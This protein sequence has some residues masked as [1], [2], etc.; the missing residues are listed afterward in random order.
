MYVTYV[1]DRKF[2]GIEGLSVALVSRVYKRGILEG[3]KA[4]CLPRFN[5]FLM[6]G[7]YSWPCFSP[8]FVPSVAWDSLSNYPQC[9]LGESWV[10][11][12]PLQTGTTRNQTGLQY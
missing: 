5:W 11:S 9:I 12:H 4:T 6:T 1:Y 10:F 2:A 3:E 8:L 7:A